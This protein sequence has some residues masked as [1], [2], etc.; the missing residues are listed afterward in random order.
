[1][2]KVSFVIPCYRSAKTLPNVVDEIRGAMAALT[3]KYTHEIILI[4]DSSPDDTYDVICDMA[5]NSNDIIG[6]N[7][8]KNFG[9]HAALMAG[10]HYA[11]GD[12]VVSLDDDGQMKVSVSDDLQKCLVKIDAEGSEVIIL[13][14]SVSINPQPAA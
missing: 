7:M 14:N 4:C 3:D 11:T 10:Y 1:M 13:D 12:I 9:Q 2:K 8:A 6:A 5:N